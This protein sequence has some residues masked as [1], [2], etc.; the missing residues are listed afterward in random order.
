MPK[1]CFSTQGAGIG[2]G[3][4][5][6]QLGFGLGVGCGIGVGFGYGMGRGLAQNENRRYSNVGSL[7]GYRSFPT[8]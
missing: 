3:I 4:P 7:S 5:G 8:Q 1:T 6:L 2:P